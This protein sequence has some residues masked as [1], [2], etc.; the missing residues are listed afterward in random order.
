MLVWDHCLSYKSCEHQT[1]KALFGIKMLV[2][3]QSIHFMQPFEG[4]VFCCG[5]RGHSMS[6]LNPIFTNK[7]NCPLSGLLNFPGILIFSGVKYLLKGF[8]ELQRSHQ[9]CIFM[10]QNVKLPDY[11]CTQM[12]K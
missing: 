4:K 2:V 8:L 1:L 3:R 11:W 10:D 9:S 7:G 6:D 5:I 12:F